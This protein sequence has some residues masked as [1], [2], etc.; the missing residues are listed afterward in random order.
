MTSW[1]FFMFLFFSQPSHDWL[2]NMP[3]F[4]RDSALSEIPSPKEMV[5]KVL[6][7]DWKQTMRAE[8]K[9]WHE[10]SWR[11]LMARN[12]PHVDKKKSKRQ[13]IRKQRV[14]STFVMGTLG[15]DDGVHFRFSEPR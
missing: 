7:P 11:R 10:P 2:A 9:T 4:K 5:E 8:A 1:S 15:L 12:R 6:L 14:G 13:R 3:S